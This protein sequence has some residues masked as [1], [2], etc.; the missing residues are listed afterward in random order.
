MANQDHAH[1]DLYVVRLF[2]NAL[3]QQTNYFDTFC[4]CPQQDGNHEK[5]CRT[6]EWRHDFDVATTALSEAERKVSP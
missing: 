6:L 1:N 2:F 5:Y 4:D 3:E